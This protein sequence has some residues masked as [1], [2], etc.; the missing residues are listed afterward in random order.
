LEDF[1]QQRDLSHT[2]VHIDM[3]AFYAAVEM[4]DDPSLK[5]KPMAVGGDNMLVGLNMA[6]FLYNKMSCLTYYLFQNCIR[7]LGVVGF[8]PFASQNCEFE[9][10][11]CLGLFM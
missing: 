3:D 6:M 8:K 9:Q 10:P 7:Y 4:R 2:I 1:E 11:Q 5:N